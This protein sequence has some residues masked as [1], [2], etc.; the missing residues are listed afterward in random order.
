MDFTYPLPPENLIKRYKGVFDGVARGQNTLLIG[1][2]FSAKAAWLK[3]ILYFD[4]NFLKKFIDPAKFKFIEI[5]D[6]NLNS[7]QLI[8]VLQNKLNPDSQPTLSD[9]FLQL[10]VLEETLKN[11]QSDKRLVIFLPRAEEMFNLDTKTIDLVSRLIK[12]RRTP[13][14]NLI[15][16]ILGGHPTL[17]E[18][19]S[20]D[21]FRPLWPFISENTQ[22]APLMAPEEC[23]YTKKRMEHFNDKKYSPVQ[24]SLATE[25]S[26]GNVLLFQTLLPM[27]QAD[28]KSIRRYR[29]HTSVDHIVQTVWEKIPSAARKNWNAKFIASY[30]FLKDLNLT[31]NSQIRLPLL[32][33][34]ISHQETDQGTKEK[35]PQLTA[36]EK[37][38]FDH[39]N[40]RS[41]E[42]ISRDELAQVIWGKLWQ[43]KYSD[44]A[45]D[46][47]ISKLRNKLYQTTLSI[48]ALRG[49]GYRLISQ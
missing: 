48:I 11:Y 40:D 21:I 28:L 1:L 39:L 27:S 38:I 5:D 14:N 8:N 18:Q 3:F 41:D 24:E 36:Q 20:N 13:P 33:P 22:F 49:R 9:Y 12:V 15:T 31:E 6:P 4:Q 37:L 43:E 45:I 26:G 29:N 25:L 23:S 34:T 47:S 44:W 2:P 46:R 16:L 17:L 19:S 10:S 42:V 35:I 32:P 7:L 30:P